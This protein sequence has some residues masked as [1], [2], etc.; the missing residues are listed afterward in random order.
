MAAVADTSPLILLAKIDRLTLLPEFY[1]QVFLPPAV[2]KELRAKPRLLPSELE[3]FIGSPGHIRS[4]ENDLRVRA[5]SANLG[6]GE[7]EAIT[8]AAEIP[9]ALL[10][11]DDTEGRRIAREL[12][13]QVTGLLG[14]LIEA[15]ARG[16]ISAMAPLLDQLRAEG[17]WLSDAMQRNVLDA[18]WE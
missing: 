3:R 15:K 14:V 17:F 12:G 1:G 5:L 7:A 6:T 18:V 2:V 8:L 10:I 4:P 11:M 9:G 13:V 16:A